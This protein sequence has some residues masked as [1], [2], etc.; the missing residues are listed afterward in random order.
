[1]VRKSDI[2][3][4][5][6]CVFG[7]Y[8][9]INWSFAGPT[10]LQD[11]IGYLAN[12]SFLAG[13]PIDGSSSYHF[14]YSLFLVPAFW[15][16]STTAAIWK[17]ILVTNALLFAAAFCVL[18][19]ILRHFNESRIACL[20]AT[21]ITATYP[22]YVTIA[23]Y[24]YSSPGEIF[25]FLC[26]CAALLW[27]ARRPLAGLSLFGLLVG[28]IFWVHPTGM[29]I[30]CAA[31]LAL[32]AAVIGEPRRALPAIVSA[33]IIVAM[34]LL[35]DRVLEPAVM[36][37]MTPEGFE[38]RS[39]YPEGRMVLS[40]LTSPSVIASVVMR[41]LGQLGYLLIAT[42][43]VAGLGLFALQT[44]A[45]PRW[46][47]RAHWR[48]ARAPVL[49]FALASLAA[50]VAITAVFFATVNSNGPHHLM[51]ARYTETVFALPLALSVLAVPSRSPWRFWPLAVIPLFV[52]FFVLIDRVGTFTNAI[53][54]AALWPSV[55]YFRP[56]PAIWFAIGLA[57]CVAAL[58]LPR[59]IRLAAM[60][61]VFAV[62]I[63]FQLK[64]HRTSF[65]ITSYPSG[66][67]E[68]VAQIVPPGTCVGV[69]PMRVK[70]MTDRDKERA[71]LYSFYLHRFD[72]RRVNAENWAS[73]CDGPFLSFRQ[74]AEL[75]SYGAVPL[76]REV[77]SQLY[78]YVRPDT[79]GRIDAVPRS[80][81]RV[82]GT[83]SGTRLVGDVPASD[84]AAFVLAGRQEG[85]KI[86]TRGRKG[87]LFYGPFAQ[88]PA[89]R[90]KVTI[91]GDVHE[92][93]GAQ[94][95]IASQGS[96]RIH[97]QVPVGDF[98]GGVIAIADVVLDEPVTDLEVRLVVTATSDLA[99]KSY[100][101]ELD[102]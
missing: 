1:M 24:S 12:A 84:I 49:I 37:A 22:A 53:N 94:V 76:A 80:M 9:A 69:D 74:P 44:Y 11:E 3:L 91:R 57:G 18:F 27:A 96:A 36:T 98:G 81:L 38:P 32:A 8:L 33:A 66:L 34:V 95:Q 21:L 93:G 56:Y 100:R 50:V 19:H 51:Y 83:V 97:K 72:Y 23:G 47:N 28:F 73:T 63:P 70:G 39:H 60:V 78:V 87:V 4:V 2:A 5:F 61:V 43:G 54:V 55:F 42:L 65:N 15:L 10:Y 88:L 26:A 6:A 86:V 52:L 25:V 13:H 30:A 89:G 82:D 48:D 79:L 99:V 46:K 29:V 64:W 62:C 71:N 90:L 75:A 45:L 14:G 20:A 59:R 7:V 41:I 40:A 58:C 102:D 16:F 101:I 67:P 35:Y 68:L 92:A 31:G 85:E 17:A 77:R